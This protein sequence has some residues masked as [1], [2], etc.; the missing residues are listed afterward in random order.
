VL[1]PASR[2]RIARV[3]GFISDEYCLEVTTVGD[4]ERLP[5]A[6]DDWKGTSSESSA[7][8]FGNKAD[9]DRSRTDFGAKPSANDSR[10]YVSPI[11]TTISQ[12]AGR[13]A[14]RCQYTDDGERCAYPFNQR[15][16]SCPSGISS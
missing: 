15:D 2:D 6:A 14:P 9:V 7:L 4:K 10:E 5:K 13:C 16:P 3:E 12:V 8:A 1:L 11:A